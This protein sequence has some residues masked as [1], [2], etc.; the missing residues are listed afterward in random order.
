MGCCLSKFTLW[1]TVG[2]CRLQYMMLY[3]N[4][5]RKYNIPKHKV[6][7]PDVQGV[8][9]DKERHLLPEISMQKIAN[10]TFPVK[11]C[12]DQGFFSN[13]SLAT[14]IFPMRLANM[15]GLQWYR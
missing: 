5:D 12:S 11:A 13:V 14:E 3:R 4:R 1:V 15:Q 9:K 2:Y 6:I 10:T 8:P 7:Q